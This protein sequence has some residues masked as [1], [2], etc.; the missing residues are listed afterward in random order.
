MQKN[1]IGLLSSD[2]NIRC[3]KKVCYFTS[4]AQ[5]DVRVFIKECHS[6]V[7]NGYDI[8]LV[9]PNAE[10][11]IVDGIKIIGVPFSSFGFVS[12][13]T[14]LPKALFETA[15]MV[16][17]DIYHFNDPGCLR[18]VK[19]LKKMGKRV[20]VDFF[21]DHPSLLFEKKGCPKFIISIFSWIYAKYEYSKVKH[22]DGVL[23][24]YHWTKDR[25]SPACPN[26]EL[27]F[28]FPILP[29]TLPERKVN[30]NNEIALGYA[31]LISPIWNFETLINA[32]PLA[33][34]KLNLAGW[35][36]DEYLNKLKQLPG[37]ENVIYYGKLSRNEVVE[38]VYDNSSIGVALLD[39]LPLCK[40]TKGNLSN[41]KMFE[42]MM[43]GLPLVCTDFD[44]W[45]EVVA[46]N[47][48]GICVNSKKPEQV[49][50][51]ITKIANDKLLA[52]QM[53]QN[54]QR[55][56]REKYNWSTQESILLD[57]YNK[58]NI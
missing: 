53:G 43:Q 51:A 4:K 52:A 34:A 41:N 11:R 48:C 47:N 24:C 37:W 16:D 55:I 29:S 35:A 40:G 12:R 18:F 45:K 21:E 42:Y 10:S 7:N 15:L 28:N 27:V 50:A 49:A 6:L 14:S 39:Y 56:I 26:I 38:K 3:M 9:C 1:Q 17:A 46:D 57:V 32:L 23:C 8:T 2:I 58:L 31:G 5:D 30:R 13:N 33:N 54:G 19:K 20:V 25:L 44:L 22:A 36:S